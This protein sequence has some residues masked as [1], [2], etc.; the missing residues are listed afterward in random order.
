MG[1]YRRI[2]VHAYRRRSNR[3]DERI[4]NAAIDAAELC[5]LPPPSAHGDYRYVVL[6]REFYGR[7]YPEVRVY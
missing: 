1:F 6:F 2:D 3:D 7:A 4:A 5:T